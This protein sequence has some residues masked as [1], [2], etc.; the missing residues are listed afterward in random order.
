MDRSRREKLLETAAGLTL[1]AVMVALIG[2]L[3]LR[4]VAIGGILALFVAWVIAHE[5]K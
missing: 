4:F 3:G 2:C 1:L 5:E